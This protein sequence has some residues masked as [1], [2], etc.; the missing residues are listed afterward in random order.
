M[1]VITLLARLI[2]VTGGV[3][4]AG[5]MIFNA[6]FLLPAMRDAGPDAAKVSAGLIRRRFLDVVP[7]VAVLTILSGLYLYWQVSARFSPAFM[8]S[9]AGIAYGTGMVTSLV[10][11]GFG[12]AIVRPSML[13][14]AALA[15][16]ATTMTG[17]EAAAAMATAQALRMRA[18]KA[19]PVVAWLLFGTAVLMAVARYL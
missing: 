13:R 3:F 2:H 10:A 11:L 7:A 8:G 16:M 12:L 15:Q 6:A 4:W 14:A 17:P 19:A 18:G 5:T 1:D 9:A